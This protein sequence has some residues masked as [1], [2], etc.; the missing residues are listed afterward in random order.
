ML[1]F[2]T[3]RMQII[4]LA[5]FNSFKND[6]LNLLAEKGNVQLIDVEKKGGYT[7]ESEQ[8]Q[9]ILSL[10]AR[11]QELN[12]TLETKLLFWPTFS[13]KKFKPSMT[14]FREME[15][16]IAVAEE[17]LGKHESFITSINDMRKSA[18]LMSKLKP[19]GIYPRLIGESDHFYATAGQIKTNNL[20]DFEWRLKEITSD[21]FLFVVNINEDDKSNA[22]LV[23][24][25]T[26][27]Y[28]DDLLRLLTTYGF[29]E[30]VIPEGIGEDFDEVIEKTRQ[31]ENEFLEEHTYELLALEEQLRIAKERLEAGALIRQE[32]NTCYLA[33]WIP[34]KNAK[35]TVEDV[36]KI[37]DSI[38]IKLEHVNFPVENF[39]SKMS[40]NR[41]VQPYEQLVVAFGRPGY[42][43]MDPSKIF[44]VIFP[45]LFGLMFAD[46]LHGFFVFILGFLGGR[47]KE[48]L[49][50]STGIIGGFAVYFRQ[51]S[52]VWMYCGFSSI[53][54]GFLFGSFGGLHG[55]A[56]PFFKAVWF[57]PL[58]VSMLEHEGY[59]VV[60]FLGVVPNFDGQFALL[61]L[62]ILVAGILL[63]LGLILNF[64]SHWKHG[65]RTHAIT[66]PGGFLVFYLALIGQLFSYGMSLDAWFNPD[67]A[68]RLIDLANVPYI[69]AF[70]LPNPTIG[71]LSLT[72]WLFLGANIFLIFYHVIW[73][74]IRHPDKLL[75]HLS[76]WLEYTLSLISN[77][78]SFARLMAIALVH[79][80]LSGVANNYLGFI[81]IYIPMLVDGYANV[82]LGVPVPIPLLG[83]LI[84]GAAVTALEMMVSLIQ[85][86][87]L[88]W[89][90]FF[91]KMG[92]QGLGKQ[93]VPYK[94][95]YTFTKAPP[96]KAAAIA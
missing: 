41:L 9:K 12:S 94:V 90:E 95:N 3:E 16:V 27:K 62:S 59:E 85:S 61:E 47:S 34:V 72:M 15:Q 7:Q 68:G 31:Q 51:G 91:T 53:I 14:A 26:K 38:I 11:F 80:I 36:K 29:S 82:Q 96:S 43:E 67:P 33:G 20:K 30:F 32:E 37:D 17:F 1:S 50:P 49:V 21:N 28:Q 39:P 65:H 73:T 10:Y 60:D 79:G 77:T 46:V 93:F 42:K 52:A 45:I 5:F 69:R 88:S 19:L 35:K 92:Y 57:L 74:G 58:S 87:R 81:S 6:V 75:D 48:P 13:S 78:I 8:E 76:E 2:E 25:V 24:G 89:V 23:V 64:Y 18:E 55:E 66:I 86:I 4:K 63:S 56:N 44:Y 22:T 84:G 40:N 70:S 71:G 83:L 54:C